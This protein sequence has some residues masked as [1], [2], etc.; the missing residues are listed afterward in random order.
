MQACGGGRENPPGR[1]GAAPVTGDA[2]GGIAGAHGG[3]RVADGL[4]LTRIRGAWQLPVASARPFR[5]APAAAAPEPR[6]RVT[7]N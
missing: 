6:L 1:T 7:V 2:A 5:L 3:L 4:N